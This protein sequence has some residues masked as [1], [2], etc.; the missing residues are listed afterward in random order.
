MGLKNIQC[1]EADIR[2]INFKPESFDVIYAH[3]SL[4]YFDDRTTTTIF[5]KLFKVLRSGG[6][7]FIKCKSVDDA[8]YG[9]GREIENDMYVSDHIRHFFSKGYMEEK[10]TKFKIVKVRRTSSVYYDY[11]SGFIEA[12]AQK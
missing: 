10:L 5:N 3:L 9:K 4:H 6:Y 1:K 12:I 11:K 8:L 7:L 2:H